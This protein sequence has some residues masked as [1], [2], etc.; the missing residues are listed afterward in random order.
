[1][2]D[3]LPFLDIAG[4]YPLL[5][6]REEILLGRRIQAWL[7]HPEPV[8]PSIARSGRRARDRFVLCNLRLVAS[9]ARYYTR[10]LDGTSLTY[11]DLLQEGTI[12]LQRAAELYSP[13]CGYKMS[14]YSSW[15]IRQSITRL[16]DRSQGTIRITRTAHKKL[17]AYTEAEAQGGSP[18]A[19]LERA[20]LGQRDHE[21]VVGARQCSVVLSTGAM[22]N[23]LED[24]GEF[25]MAAP[26]PPD[27][28]PSG[29]RVLR[30]IAAPD[31]GWIL[32]RLEDGEKVPAADLQRLRFR[33][34]RQAQT[35]LQS[36]NCLSRGL[37]RYSLRAL[38]V[39][40]RQTGSPPLDPQ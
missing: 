20:G 40:R 15:W 36:V 38:L 21:L 3:D 14:T 34:S 22:R 16:L 4:K 35:L 37:C 24:G 29:Y 32:E 30:D 23:K 27:S 25:E 7:A 9:I 39:E 31:L 8:P 26:P 17:T 5:T 11:S 18:A 2:S 13:T 28:D 19:I 6:R 12:G 33:I 1:V 10:R